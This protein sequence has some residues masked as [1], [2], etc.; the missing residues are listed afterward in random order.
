MFDAARDWQAGNF[1][2]GGIRRIGLENSSAVRLTLAA[3]V[4]ANIVATLDS[5]RADIVGGR[6]RVADAFEGTEF[7]P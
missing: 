6:I 5:L 3:S 1:P 7:N 2:A 4:P